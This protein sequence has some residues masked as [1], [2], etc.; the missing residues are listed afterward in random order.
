MHRSIKIEIMFVFFASPTA[1]IVPSLFFRLNLSWII[2]SKKESLIEFSIERISVPI[3]TAPMLGTGPEYLA[4]GPR[5]L[6][7]LPCWL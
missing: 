2:L 6:V 7:A 5:G 3:L 4:D 1:I